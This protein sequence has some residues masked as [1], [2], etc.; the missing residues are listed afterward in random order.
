MENSR[1]YFLYST[2]SYFEENSSWEPLADFYHIKY[3]IRFTLL[4]TEA[5]CLWHGYHMTNKF[6]RIAK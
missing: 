4:K 6:L 5:A 2:N 3:V 1:Q